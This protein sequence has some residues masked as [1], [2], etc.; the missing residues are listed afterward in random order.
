ME[1]PKTA[2]KKVMS[3]VSFKTGLA[4]SANNVSFDKLQLVPDNSTLKGWLSVVLKILF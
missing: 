3:K 2:D 4:D 1:A